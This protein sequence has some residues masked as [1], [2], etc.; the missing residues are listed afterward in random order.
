MI[1]HLKQ[2]SIGAALCLAALGAARAD[3]LYVGGS[4]GPPD[5]RSSIN[6]IS[7]NGSGIGGKLYGG[8]QLMPN[9][10]I[11]GGLFDLGHIDNA[12]GKVNTRG[13]YVDAVGS[14]EFAPRWMMLGSAGVAQGHFTSTG[15]SDSSSGLKFGAGLQYEL[16]RQVALRAQFEHYHFSDAFDGKP[17]VDAFTFGVKIGF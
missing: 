12:T 16:S 13:V 9:W 7:G 11:E 3:G 10:A 14:Y 4:L 17:N 8:Y 15:G 5:Y 6:G 2:L 1:T